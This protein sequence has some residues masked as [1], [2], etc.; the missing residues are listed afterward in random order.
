[1]ISKKYIIA[2]K[3]ETYYKYCKQYPLVKQSLIYVRKKEDLESITSW[4]IIV[5]LQGWFARKWAVEY[6]SDIMENN[7]GFVIEEQDG[8][9][10]EE[11]R[12]EILEKINSKRKD[13]K[14]DRIP[15]RFD[16]L[17]I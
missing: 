3:K 17:D 10:G 2:G 16:L 13:L 1:M 9:F 15:S 12:K 8:H 14:S 11:K 6:V 5:L 4:D 7:P